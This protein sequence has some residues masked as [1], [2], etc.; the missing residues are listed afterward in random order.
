[1]MFCSA[2]K[3]SS[4][5]QQCTYIL[6]KRDFSFWKAALKLSGA[7]SVNFPFKKVTFDIPKYVLLQD[8]STSLIIF[9]FGW[10]ES[11]RQKD[12]KDSQRNL[13]N[14]QNS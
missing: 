3:Q 14:I 2:E 9:W 1:M 8:L 4:A 5:V 7:S 13:V 6:W 11:Y 10:F 12:G